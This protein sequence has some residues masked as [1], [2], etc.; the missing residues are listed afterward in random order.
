ML[1]SLLFFV[2]MCHA[3]CLR[4]TDLV[5]CAEWNGRWV[6]TCHWHPSHIDILAQAL[7]IE[8][9]SCPKAWACAMSALCTATYNEQCMYA[10]VPT[11]ACVANCSLTAS[12][13]TPPFPTWPPPPLPTAPAN[14]PWVDPATPNSALRKTINGTTYVAVFSDEFAPGVAR[15]FEYGMDAKW[16]A[17]THH[18]S[19]TGDDECYVPSGARVENGK[20]QI[21]L[22]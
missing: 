14:T 4:A 1:L 3:G 16:E 18:Y 11:S 20:V 19:G 22:G 9:P 8:T 5:Y 12:Y 2:A 15:N 7:A 10:V 17:L 6:G 13:V 21:D